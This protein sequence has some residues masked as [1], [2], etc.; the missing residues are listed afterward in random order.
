MHSCISIALALL[1]AVGPAISAPITLSPNVLLY[2]P[3]DITVPTSGNSVDDEN[4][5][6][7]AM[8]EP[9]FSGQTALLTEEEFASLGQRYRELAEYMALN[10]EKVMQVTAEFNMMR[11]K[12]LSGS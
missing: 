3:S 2:A 12:Q 10:K 8:L 9:V 1:A 4:V 6:Q 11:A 7:L 5:M